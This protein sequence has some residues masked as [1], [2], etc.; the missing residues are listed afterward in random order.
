DMS[1]FNQRLFSRLDAAADR[2]GI[3][4]LARTE[5]RRRH[6]RWIPILA[7]ALAM[8]GWAWGL[9]RPDGTYPGYALISAGFV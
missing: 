9:A 5:V 8:G 1:R 7:L 6:L 2:T 3:P 4:A